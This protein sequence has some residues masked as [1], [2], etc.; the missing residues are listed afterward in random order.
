MYAER[1]RQLSGICR[2]G[3][4]EGDT[5]LGAWARLRRQLI[6]VEREALIGLR[7]EGRVPAAAMRE[8]ERDL[9][10]EEERLNRLVPEQAA[11]GTPA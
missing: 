10:L 5:D 6:Q 1:A 9:D 7:N 2:E 11:A 8:V 3:V 4:P